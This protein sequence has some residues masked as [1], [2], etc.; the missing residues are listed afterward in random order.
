MKKKIV[1]SCG[2]ISTRLDSVK[3]ITNR[4]KGGLAFRTAQQL[5]DWAMMIP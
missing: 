3:C 5:I 2:P 1:V 4:F